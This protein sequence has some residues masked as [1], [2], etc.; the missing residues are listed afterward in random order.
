MM[1]EGKEGNEKIDLKMSGV[2]VGQIN[3]NEY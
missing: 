2:I 1:P 3:Q